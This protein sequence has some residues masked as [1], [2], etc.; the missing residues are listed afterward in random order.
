MLEF[1]GKPKTLNL[2]RGPGHINQGRGGTFQFNWKDWNFPFVPSKTTRDKCKAGYTTH[3]GIIKSLLVAYLL[4]ATQQESGVEPLLR[5]KSQL[6]I[7]AALA[8]DGLSLK[9]GLQFDR[10]VKELVGLIFPVDLNYVKNN[11][12]PDPNEMRKAFVVEANSAV[13]TTLDN[14]LSLPLGNDFSPKGLNGNDIQNRIDTRVKQLQIC[15]HCLLSSS[16]T[17]GNVI[18]SSGANCS[19]YC[20]DCVQ[21]TQVCGNC[22][23]SGQR[24]VEVPLRACSRC[25]ASGKQCV[26]LFIPVWTADCE[27]NNK[28]AMVK[29][30]EMKE[31][32]TNSAELQLLVPLP[33]ATHVAKCLKGSFANWFVFKAGERFN[34]SNLRVLYNDPDPAL[35]RRMRDVTTLSAVRNRDRM[36]V[37]DL[38]IINRESVRGVL[39]EAKLTVQTLIPEPF[40]LYK[41]NARGVLS[42]P[43]GL[44]IAHEGKLLICDHSKSRLF[45]GRLRYPVDVSELSSNLK[46]PN[47]VAF[48]NGVAY[49]V[50]GMFS[51]ALYDSL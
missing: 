16:E 13:V 21:S 36:S 8:T 19:R 27:E 15:L 22:E 1:H 50:W 6:L 49:V 18:L 30:L 40:R 14:K 12:V 4:I 39:R 10:R 45:Q 46:N 2:L 7:P 32:G 37:P 34:L 25:I 42:H 17:R 48:H 35:R 20:E 31:K 26:S 23:A 9:P 43:T 28:Q 33:E 29:L 5:N 44:C 24:F 47:G 41:G 11:P 51:L 38:L 3:N